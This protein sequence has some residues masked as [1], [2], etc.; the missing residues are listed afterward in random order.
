M[1][2]FYLKVL[3]VVLLFLYSKTSTA[4]LQYFGVNFGF[5]LGNIVQFETNNFGEFQRTHNGSIPFC[6]G[7][8]LYPIENFGFNFTTMVSAITMLSEDASARLASP[9]FGTLDRNI[10]IFGTKAAARFW[11]ADIDESDFNLGFETGISTVRYRFLDHYNVMYSNQSLSI[12]N[13]KSARWLMP[14]HFGVN[15]RLGNIFEL[16]GQFNY[17]PSLK[18]VNNSGMPIPAIPEIQFNAPLFNQS[19]FS[20]SFRA[21]ILG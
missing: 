1:K 4:Q 2:R 16:G 9:G 11:L 6:M 10:S 13:I 20:F 8:E 15:V 12:R 3:V 17:F 14:I 21:C 5:N 7:I 18:D 19:Y